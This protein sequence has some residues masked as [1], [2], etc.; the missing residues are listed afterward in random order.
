MHGT[1]LHKTSR[2]DAMAQD[3][4]RDLLGRDWD[5]LLGDETRDAS[6]WDETGTLRIFPRWDVS[7]SWDQDVSTETIS[8]LRKVRDSAKVTVIGISY[9]KSHKLFQSTPKLATSNNLETQNK[10]FI[11]DFFCVLGCNA[12]L[13]SELHQ[14]GWRY[15]QRQLAC[16]IF[17]IKCEF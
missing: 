8:L 3:P 15:R 17:S 11:S 12:H 4:R 9:R 13:K 10:E 1:R 6:V 14:N 5:I 7:T 16:K 2:W